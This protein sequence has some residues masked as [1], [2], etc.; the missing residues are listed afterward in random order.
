VAELLSVVLPTHDRPERLREAARSVLSQDYPSV[1]LVV[2]DDGSG[3]PTARILDELAAQDRR[4]VV[5]RHQQSL[6]SAAARNAG[7]ALASGELV[8][9]CDDDDVWLPEAASAA[10]AA[11][12]P[13][14]GVVYGWHQVL[15]EASGR[16]VTFRP[17]AECGPSVMRWINVPSILSGVARRSV[18]GDAL[19]FDSALSTSEDW[20]L[21][22]RCADMAPMTLVP[23]ALYRYVQHGGERVSRGSGD[24]DVSHQRFLDKHRSSM[25]PNCIAHH[26]LT[27]ALARR[28]LKAGKEQVAALLVHP[29]RVG[30]ASLLAG[31]LL[32]SRV[33]RG[34]GDPGLPLRFA[35]SVV[36]RVCDRPRM[37]RVTGPS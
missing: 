6:G 16:C 2:V 33:G 13:S 9:F 28:H 14:T 8:A 26:E 35:A 21:W 12:K 32:A 34:R 29:T 18:L 4:V 11:S 31:E 5:L 37:R 20:D 15:H 3:A 36:T 27:I 7:L 25:S 10:V 17:P 23:T 1:E 22:L 19:T 24:H 30:P